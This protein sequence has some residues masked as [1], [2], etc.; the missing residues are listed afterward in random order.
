MGR[1]PDCIGWRQAER[2]QAMCGLNDAE[3]KITLFSIAPNGQDTT[4]MVQAAQTFIAQPAG[5]LTIYGSC[6]NAKTLI[7]QAV[8]NAMLSQGV[9][10]I[11]TTFY[12]LV[13]WIREAYNDRE[14]ESAWRRVK[15][16]QD[17]RVLCI[18]ELDKVKQS[19]W[20][21]EVETQLL[22]ARYRDGIAGLSGTLLA[23]NGNIDLLSDHLESRLRDG[24]NVL[25]QNNDPDMRRVMA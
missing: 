2:L 3:R 18:D 22:D 9:A 1:C 15:R 19:E 20:V 11:Y 17:V 16:L 10:A 21:S 7:L 13:N 14:N 24:R 23:M 4:R 6:G 25:I 8:V 5:F 12:D